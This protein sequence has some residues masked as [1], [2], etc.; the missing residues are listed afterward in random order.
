M[1][2]RRIA[3]ISGEGGY[4]RESY[5]DTKSWKIFKPCSQSEILVLMNLLFR[6]V[7]EKFLFVVFCSAAVREDRGGIFRSVNLL[8]F[9]CQIH[10]Y[11]SRGH[12]PKMALDVEQFLLFM[13][14]Q[15]SYNGPVLKGLYDF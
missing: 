5:K 10:L 4:C 12:F 6:E 13:K 8:L 15:N 2:H 9:Q 14:F 3:A 1:H 11:V 7:G